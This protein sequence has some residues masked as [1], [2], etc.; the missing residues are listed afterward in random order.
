MNQT[1]YQIEKWDIDEVTGLLNFGGFERAA[2]NL[3]EEYPDRK[4]CIMF[5]DIVDF[6]FI[7]RFFGRESGNRILKAVSR[8]FGRFEDRYPFVAGRLEGDRFVCCAPEEMA[9]EINWL[10]ATDNTLKVEDFEYHFRSFC[11]ITKASLREETIADLVDMAHI[12]M[13]DIKGDYTKHYAWYNEDSWQKSIQQRIL[14]SDFEKAIE[15]KQFMPFFQPIYQ[16]N[17]GK[18][19]GAEVLTRWK[20]PRYGKISPADFIPLFEGNGYI[21]T[22]DRFIWRETCRVIREHRD[23]GGVLVPFSVNVSQIEFLSPRLPEIIKEIVEESGLSPELIRIEITESAYTSYPRQVVESTKKLREY[24]FCILMDDFGKGLSSLSMLK[25]L[26][27]DELKID[28]E[29][30]KDIEQNPNS[31]V[32][33]ESVIKMAKKLGMQTLIEGV[34]TEKQ[35]EYIKT[36]GCDYVQG[37]YYSKPMPTDQMMET[38]QKR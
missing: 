15:E 6:K 12:A 3:L 26:P 16:V 37:Y 38:L 5:W 33:L 19:S 21:G 4:F 25:D 31:A 30:I 11:G 17:S 10:R 27:I 29:F 14:I 2:A 35:A 32:I 34:E 23:H 7:N 24:G 1:G 9:E 28:M 20:H 22:L 18:I 8:G 13:E 36:L